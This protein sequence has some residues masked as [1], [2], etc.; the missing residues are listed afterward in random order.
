[1]V[2][3]LACVVAIPVW[4]I[5]NPVQP[6][7]LPVA[8]DS[9][10]RPPSGWARV[11][12]GAPTWN[13]VFAGADQEER[14]TYADVHGRR[15]DVFVATYAM[16]RQKKELI[17]Y[18]NSLIGADEGAVVS[19]ASADAGAPAHEL[20]VEKADQ[21][22]LIRYYYLVGNRRTARGVVAQLWYGLSALSGTH[23]SSVVAMRAPCVPD[24]DSARA[25]LNDFS[26]R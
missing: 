12:S 3:A 11:S 6:A 15:L 7:S 8:G 19:S 26:R 14:A 23:N 13:P 17:A 22:A 2:A 16:Q 9:L 10:P 24:C 18:G 1:M 20:V 5:A 25:L 21:R 4:E